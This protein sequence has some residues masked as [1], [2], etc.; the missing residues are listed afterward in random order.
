MECPADRL[1]NERPDPPCRRAAVLIKHLENDQRRS[2]AISHS[3]SGSGWRLAENDPELQLAAKRWLETFGPYQDHET[4]SRIIDLGSAAIVSLARGSESVSLEFKQKVSYVVAVKLSMVLVPAGEYSV[5]DNGVF[6]RAPVTTPFVPCDPQIVAG[7]F[8]RDEAV[9]KIK[10]L[11]Q[12]RFQQIM[13][14][15]QGKIV[16]QLFSD[17][18]LSGAGDEVPGS[19][20]RK[21][22]HNKSCELRRHDWASST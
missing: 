9:A 11:A 18:I 12:D 13:T 8:S 4:L 19:P 6:K 14:K 1:V 15:G 20:I 5:Y 10:E 17:N 7:P 2:R 22:S 16:Y 3:W 21:G